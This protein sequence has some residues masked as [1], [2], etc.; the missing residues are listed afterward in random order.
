MILVQ[1]R[2][3]DGKCCEE[4]PRYPKLD[5][6]DC[7]YHI[8]G[9][10]K[11]NSGCALMNGDAVSPLEGDLKVWPGQNNSVTFQKTCVDWPQNSPIGRGTGGCCWQWV[12]GD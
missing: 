10:G 3:C 12:D 2:V 7:V 9:I 8:K 4:S 1:V 11:E 6:L 5:N